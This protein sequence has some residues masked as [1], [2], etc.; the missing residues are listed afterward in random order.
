MKVELRCK[1]IEVIN[2]DWRREVTLPALPRVGDHFFIE[3]SAV[4][5]TLF[6][7]YD[8]QGDFPGFMVPPREYSGMFVV[9]RVQF[10]LLMDDG[11]YLPDVWI[12]PEGDLLYTELEYYE[13]YEKL[14]G[15]K[16]HY[17]VAAWIDWTS[18]IRSE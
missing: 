3:D 15:A 8:K 16:M 1:Q 4:V 14:Y 11:K 18:M 17:P 6:H 10:W 5:M 9:E 12:A 2:E 7:R 13:E